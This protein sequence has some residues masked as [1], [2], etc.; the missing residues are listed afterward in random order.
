MGSISL[1]SL[2]F[3]AT[4]PLFSDLSL[5]I[6]DGD[7]VG[8]VAGNGNGKTTLLRCIAGQLEPST[9][10]IIRSRGL[11]VGYVEQDVPS[12][13]HGLTLRDAVLDALPEET[14]DSDSWRADV[15]LDDFD[16]PDDM[17]ER[18]VAALSGGWQRLMLIARV[19]VNE[20]DALLLDE[21]T[22]H[23][24]LGKILMVE[25]WLNTNARNLPVIVASHD[26]GF[27]DATTNRTLFLRPGTSHYFA[28]PFTRARAALAEADEAAEK[29]QE[30]ELKDAQQLRRQAAKLTN[31]G[32][33]SGSDLLTLKAKYLKER[34]AKIEAASPLLHKERSGEIR[35]GNSGTHARVLVAVENV[36]VS[37]PDAR[38]L[39]SV[40]K[41]HLF[42]GD[43][44]VLL[45]RNGAGK[46]QFVKLLHRAMTGEVVP[47]IRVAT[48]LTLGY[49][50][51]DMSQLPATGTPFDF[52]AGFGQGDQRTKALLAAAGFD[53]DRQGK[54]IGRLSFGQ[55]ARLALL[56]LRLGEPNFYLMDEPTNHVDIAGQ[57]RLEAEILEHEASCILVSHDRSFVRN[58]GT[59]F[60]EI[61]RGRLVEAD[62]P[63]AFFAASGGADKGR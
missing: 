12:A 47:G 60:L 40:Q 21:P 51:Q 19:W 16:T 59:R 52:I 5:V 11:R 43:R 8:L 28:L 46:S 1:N 25:R 29:K 38:P 63:E 15:V 56:A 57:E 9:G 35:L 26:R 2:G 37:T 42:Q 48:S 7:R 20:P 53:I 30:R 62:D 6:G 54:P 10:A 13:L 31:I 17:R 4:T 61:V 58:V 33:N 22:N 14:R 50:D 3:T 18:P 36:T 27:L 55:R 41:L 49:T 44:V 45:G 23:L 32:I 39:F 34:A 24:D